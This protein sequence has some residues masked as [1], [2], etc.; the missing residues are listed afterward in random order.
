MTDAHSSGGSS[1]TIVL[2]LRGYRKR[3]VVDQATRRVIALVCLHR[4]EAVRVEHGARGKNC[5]IVA[6]QAQALV[7]LSHRF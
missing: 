2:A 3:R 1:D 5:Q 6:S 7:Q 4:H